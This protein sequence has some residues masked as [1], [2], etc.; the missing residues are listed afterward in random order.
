[1]IWRDTPRVISCKIGH[2]IS[3]RCAADGAAPGQALHCFFFSSSNAT[4]S[5][6]AVVDGVHCRLNFTSSLISVGSTAAERRCVKAFRFKGV[7]AQATKVQIEEQV[8]ARSALRPAEFARLNTLAGPS[9]TEPS[10]SHDAD[11][12]VREAAELHNFQQQPTEVLVCRP[13]RKRQQPEW[14]QPTEELLEFATG[15]RKRA[16]PPTQAASCVGD[17]P[18][19]DCRGGRGAE[20]AEE[21]R[22][23]GAGAEEQRSRGAEEQAARA[24]AQAAIAEAVGRGRLHPRWVRVDRVEGVL[25]RTRTGDAKARNAFEALRHVGPAERAVHVDD[26]HGVPCW[27]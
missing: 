1:M 27:Q 14:L 20:E 24:A 8:R 17:C 10:E 11:E 5:L 25:R 26:P 12:V 6:L 3:R 9:L 7:A 4:A 21:Q 22:S 13:T 2:T 16:R 23:S 18:R 19:E 15:T